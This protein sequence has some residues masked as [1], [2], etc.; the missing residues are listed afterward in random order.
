MSSIEL[1][2][3]DHQVADE[4]EAAL[5]AEPEPAGWSFDG[6]ETGPSESILFV[7]AA[8]P[9][10]LLRWYSRRFRNLAPVTTRVVDEV[11]QV[12]EVPFDEFSKIKIP[13]APR[14]RQYAVGDYFAI[15][16]APGMN[17]F[18]RYQN[19]VIGTGSF[20][21]ILAGISPSVEPVWKLRNRP[22]A[23]PPLGVYLP[24]VVKEGR[25]TFLGREPGFVPPPL[26]LFR[27]R[28]PTG[29]GVDPEEYIWDI[30]ALDGSH[31]ELVTEL[32]EEQAK[33][34]TLLAWS[35]EAFVS[36]IRDEIANGAGAFS[37]EDGR[38]RGSN[39]RVAARD[40]E[41]ELGR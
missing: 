23:L 38:A 35:A 15:P 26:P 40:A 28:I 21:G 22:L 9:S 39:S 6:R 37:L 11:G 19:E 1:I 10:A 32:S 14:R 33:L 2:F 3:H 5:V 12:V 41:W 13:A 25:W 18:A 29:R 27:Q 16:I 8:K 7:N 17:A 34:G 30:V 20:V 36:R 31:N 24:R 4:V